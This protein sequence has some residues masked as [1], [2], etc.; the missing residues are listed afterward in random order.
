MPRAPPAPPAPPRTAS[1][2]DV[3][4]LLPLPIPSPPHPR[5]S[6]PFTAPLVATS[7]EAE[8]GRVRHSR[9]DLRRQDSPD[10][11]DARSG[12]APVAGR[13]PGRP[14]TEIATPCT[15][16]LPQLILPR[17]VLPGRARARRSTRATR[18]SSRRCTCH[19]LCSSTSTSDTR[20]FLCPPHATRGN[21][22]P[23]SLDDF[24]FLLRITNLHSFMMSNYCICGASCQ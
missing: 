3:D 9:A 22:V 5:L 2:R 14:T 11:R 19:P 21:R 13:R 23:V 7:R 16:I 15:I 1:P 24:Y 17:C 6:S 10:P 18:P 4:R 20:V 8:D 12:D